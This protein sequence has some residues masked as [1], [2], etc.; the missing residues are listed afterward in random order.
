M[1]AGW[2]LAVLLPLLAAPLALA[3]DEPPPFG[4][5]DLAVE[6]DLL[7]DGW[8]VLYDE[9][10]DTP[11]EAIETWAVEVA[12]SAGVDEDDL[13]F[14]IR[15]L[16]S[17]EKVHATLLVV[18][19]DGDPT[20]LESRL[21][22]AAKEKGWRVRALAHPTRLLV[23]AAPSAM[24][25]KL[26]AIQLAAAVKTLSRL[27]FERYDNGSLRGAE[28][29]AEGALALAP[30]AETP[31]AVLGLAAEKEQRWD[32]A[33]AAF[34]KAFAGK[35]AMAPEARL[36][37]WAWQSYG[38]CLLKQKTKAAATKAATAFEQAIGLAEFAKKREPVFPVYYNH[39]CA[40]T[41]T[42][43]YPKACAQLEKAL[44]LAKKRL[45]PRRFRQVTVAEV[46]KDPDLEKLREQPCFEEMM[47]RV[48]A[49]TG[50]S[51]LDGI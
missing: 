36:A 35:T 12:G 34:E 19:V 17:P 1:R 27:G 40:L 18:E 45:G 48:T 3:D 7:P 23:I 8:S 6:E 33:V 29:F 20:A 16:E 42:G 39:A 38:L 24:L 47:D 31:H 44:E 5:S 28:R 25:D 46:Q 43:E 9:V 15:V 50:R 21:K 30:D 13:L 37:F 22:R 11:G 26:E 32:D 2:I 51:P 49:D 14:E 10:D 41:L 4:A